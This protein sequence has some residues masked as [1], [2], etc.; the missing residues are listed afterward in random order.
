MVMQRQPTKVTNNASEIQLEPPLVGRWCAHHATIPAVTSEPLQAKPL[1]REAALRLMEIWLFAM[2]NVFFQGTLPPTNVLLQ[3]TGHRSTR[4]NTEIE[5]DRVP[6]LHDF[7]LSL[8]KAYGSF[9]SGYDR[10][11][12]KPLGIFTVYMV[13]QRQ[14]TKVTNNASE[15]QLEPPLIGRWCAHHATIPAVTSEPLQA[16]PLGRGAA[17]RLM[18]IWLFAMWNVFFQGTLPPTNVLLQMT[19]HRSTRGNTEIEGHRVPMLH[20]FKLSEGGIFP[21]DFTSTRKPPPDSCGI[22]SDFAPALQSLLHES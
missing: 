20:D 17:L 15:I 9:T 18:E 4:G 7:K 6:M 16:K 10:L 21:L 13:M 1:G 11:N 5:G 12:S 19:G 2:W 14:P 22:A 3:M 8:F